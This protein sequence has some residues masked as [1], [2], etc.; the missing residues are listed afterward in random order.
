MQLRITTQICHHI[1]FSIPESCAFLHQEEVVTLI[2]LSKG[3]IS[4]S[5]CLSK[6][7]IITR[8]GLFKTGISNQYNGFSES[9]YY[10]LQAGIALNYGLKSDSMLWNYHFEQFAL[11]YISDKLTEELPARQICSSKLLKLRQYDKENN[12]E[13]YDTLKFYLNNERNT[14]QTANQLFIHRSTLFYRLNRIKAMLDINLDIPE[15]RLYLQ[16]SCYLLEH[17][18]Q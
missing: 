9:R 8:E 2:N 11:E 18:V 10:Y 15:N 7:A 12:T 17:C 14:V 5:D 13:L 4:S 1:E 6:L 16:L 3:G